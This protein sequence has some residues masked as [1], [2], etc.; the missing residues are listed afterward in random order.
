[1]SMPSRGLRFFMLPGELTDVLS[2]VRESIG[3][4]LLD[5][6]GLRCL[7]DDQPFRTGPGLYFVAPVLE[8]RARRASIQ[9][10]REGWLS[11]TFPPPTHDVIY[12][13]QLGAKSEWRDDTG[14]G[15]DSPEVIEL[16]RKVSRVFRIT[17][18]FGVILVGKASSR[19]V[20]DIGL[21]AGARAWADQGNQLRQLGVLHAFR[22][23]AAV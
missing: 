20:K 14:E 12:L 23:P 16:F 9:P 6:E 22:P 1:M 17:L 7:A 11:L 2:V 3:V 19:H 5:H 4:E 15:R 13:A 8:P 18:T 10:G 21:S